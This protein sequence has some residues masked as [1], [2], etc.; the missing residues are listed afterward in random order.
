VRFEP[1]RAAEKLLK[2]LP[3]V[4]SQLDELGGKIAASAS[5]ATAEGASDDNIS[6]PHYGHAVHEGKDGAFVNVWTQSNEA[7]HENARDNTLIKAMR[8]GR[9]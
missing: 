2:S 5:S 8:A 4:K 1:N 7:K 6:Y 9:G 3:K